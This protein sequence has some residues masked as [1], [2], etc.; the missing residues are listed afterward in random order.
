MV[1][2]ITRYSPAQGIDRALRRIVVEEEVEHGQGGARNRRGPEV[3]EDLRVLLGGEAVDHV[4]REHRVVSALRLRG[5]RV[6][7]LDRGA[8]RHTRRLDRLR[9]AALE[10]GA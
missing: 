3:A 7:D 10:P 5:R 2:S 9:H 1:P 6:A 8:V 4:I